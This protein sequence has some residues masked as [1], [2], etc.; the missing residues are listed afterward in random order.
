[1]HVSKHVNVYI[2]NVVHIKLPSYQMKM[3]GICNCEFPPFAHWRLHTN[4]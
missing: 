1:M 2:L 3:F 4:S